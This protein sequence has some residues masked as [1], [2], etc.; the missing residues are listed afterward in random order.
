MRSR[1]LLSMFCLCL[2]SLAVAQEPPE[3][4]EP[5]LPPPSPGVN[6]ALGKTC[7]FDPAPSYGECS[8]A[9]DATDLT[10]GIYNGCRWRETGTVGWGVGRTK[11][12]TVDV[13]LGSE[14]PLGKITFD[15]TP[16]ARK[17]PSRRRSW[18][19]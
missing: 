3:Q 8:E 1:L 14:Q 12:F 10:D 9:G 15:S 16:A 11:S 18:P 6:V 5:P 13:D 4:P 2:I 17:S 7:T 19:S